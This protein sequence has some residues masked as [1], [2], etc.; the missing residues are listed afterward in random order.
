MIRPFGP[1]EILSR[2]KLVAA[3][4][5]IFPATKNLA[6]HVATA[7]VLLRVRRLFVVR[8]TDPRDMPTLDAMVVDGLSMTWGSWE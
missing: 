2:E 7:H 6:E 1:L 5:P 8:C 4:R 3:A